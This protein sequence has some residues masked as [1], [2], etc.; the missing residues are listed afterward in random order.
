MVPLATDTNQPMRIIA[1]SEQFAQISWTAAWS[2]G[3]DSVAQ[4]AGTATAME[5]YTSVVDAPD[6][7]L[8][9]PMLVLVRRDETGVTVSHEQTG[10][11]GAGDDLAAAS[12]DFYSALVE[13]RE[14]LAREPRLSP[15]L[16]RLLVYLAG[17]LG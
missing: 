10:I 8:H 6:G 12:A 15:E 5:Y 4:F 1:R 13:H 3:R 7:R 11:Y 17:Q 9:M 16:Q 14:L 2:G